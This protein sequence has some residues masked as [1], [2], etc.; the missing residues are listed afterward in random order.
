MKQDWAMI[1]KVE[2]GVI[3]SWVKQRMEEHQM[4]TVKRQLCSVPGS[5][6]WKCSHGE[7]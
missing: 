3:Q 4:K 5:S 6:A 7:E 1:E 2:E